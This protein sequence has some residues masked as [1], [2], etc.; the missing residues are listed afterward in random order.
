MW[1]TSGNW[2]CQWTL[3]LATLMWFAVPQRQTTWPAGF[4]STMSSSMMVAFD[5]RP[6][7]ERLTHWLGTAG[8]SRVTRSM[9]R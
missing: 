9:P 1:I 3:A 5:D 7:E 2:S 4:S 6:H 8:Q